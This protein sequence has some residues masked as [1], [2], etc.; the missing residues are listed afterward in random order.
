[1]PRSGPSRVVAVT[2]AVAV[3]AGATGWFAGSRVRSPADA[4]AAH[5]PPAASLIT[6]AV[7][8]RTLTATVNAQGTVAYGAP[9]P[10]TLTGSVATAGDAAAPIVT[11]APVAGRTLREGDVLLEV[12]GRPVFVLA[13]TVPMY[14][15]VSRGSAGDDVRQV[16]AA[17]RRLLPGRGVARSGAVDTALLNALARW[18]DKRGYEIT[19]PTAEQ[20]AQLRQLEAD[21]A[22][23]AELAEFRKTYG[24]SV[25]SGEILFVPR[26]PVRLTEVKVRPGAPAAGEV[27]TVADPNLVINGT[28]SP[29]DA[30]LIKTGMSAALEHAGGDTFAAT[31]SSLG[32]PVKAGVGET[33]A[34][35]GV[36]IRLKPKDQAK[37]APLVGEAVKVTITVGGTGHKVLSVPVAAVY[38][39]SDGQARVTVQDQGGRVRDVPVEAGLST[40]GFVQITPADKDAV[41]AGSLVVVGNQ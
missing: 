4:A 26:L 37:I 19:G 7:R 16:R 8:E 20:R 3:A 24:D 41:R 15:T 17:L 40:G 21:P 32:G 5:R 1:M 38:T 39:A 9:K 13:G 33:E 12:S 30:D 11:K 27:G 14:R 22:A 29:D 10:L 35:P 2:A 6:V 28:V 36:P 23:A 34:D 18:Y 25:P 31:I